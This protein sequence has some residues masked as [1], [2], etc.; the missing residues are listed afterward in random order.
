[1]LGEASVYHHMDLLMGRHE[2]L[3]ALQYWETILQGLSRL[4]SRGTENFLCSPLSFP[5]CFCSKQPW[6][7]ET[8]C[9]QSR[10][11]FIFLLPHNKGN[12]SLREISSRFISHYKE[13]GS[14]NLGFI[15][16]NATPLWNRHH[17]VHFALTHGN[18]GSRLTQC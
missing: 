5:G 4:V 9:L 16:F 15:S 6:Q 1:M 10:G 2:C 18:W 13:V 14:L 17:L 7:I 8:V 12:V 3:V 11:Q